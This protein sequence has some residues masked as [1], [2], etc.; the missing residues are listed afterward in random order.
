[1]NDQSND[2]QAPKTEQPE[3][4]QELHDGLHSMGDE[5]RK[6]AGTLKQDLKVNRRQHNTSWIWGVVLIFAGGL[7]L[8]QNMTN[9]QVNNWWAFFILIPSISSFSD[10][11]RRF[12]DDGRFSGRV[13]SSLVS[14]VILLGI[15]LFFLLNLSLG[16]FWPVLLILGGLL[17][18]VNTLLPE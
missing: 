12:Q 13:R 17:I 15:A 11:W 6:G 9:F 8:L 14:G 7:F 18:L 4:A 16:G 5:M 3:W 10:A 2:N 1:M